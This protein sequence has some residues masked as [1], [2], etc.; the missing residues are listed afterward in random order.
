MGILIVIILPMKV[1]DNI[2]IV[3]DSVTSLHHSQLMNIKENRMIHHIILM[4]ITL[5][6][7]RLLQADMIKVMNIAKI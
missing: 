3:V 4:V 1:V 5:N 2:Y 7:G 6:N